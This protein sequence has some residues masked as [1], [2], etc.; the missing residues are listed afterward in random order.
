MTIFSFDVGALW[1]TATHAAW[2]RL[3]GPGFAVLLLLWATI[4]LSAVV[5][6]IQASR[7]R[8]S[9]RDFLRHLVPAG[10]V[11]HAS[12]RADF[13]FWLSRHIVLPL[14]VV[15]LLFSTVVAGHVAYSVL[16]AVLGPPTHP[17]GPAGPVTL[18]LFTL[19][20]L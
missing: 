10:T 12:A 14:M 6:Y 19:T 15:P 13:L 1:H 2:D 17:P 8:R 7:E 5:T 3:S 18:V 4:L 20:M 16:A 9:L 11:Q